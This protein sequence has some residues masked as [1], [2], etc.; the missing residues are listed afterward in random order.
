MWLNKSSPFKNFWF[1]WSDFLLNSSI[2]MMECESI[3]LRFFI[4]GSAPKNLE[5]QQGW[6]L[7]SSSSSQELSQ[8]DSL[9]PDWFLTRQSGARRAL[10]HNWIGD[11]RWKVRGKWNGYVFAKFSIDAVCV[12]HF[13]AFSLVYIF[14]KKLRQKF[15]PSTCPLPFI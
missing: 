11:F 14:K 15:H 10:W 13:T 5:I 3:F 12:S 2:F 7:M 6:N 8:W 9:A 1:F 4:L